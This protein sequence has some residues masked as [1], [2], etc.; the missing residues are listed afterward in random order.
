MKPIALFILILALSM[1][2]SNVTQGVWQLVVV[3]ISGAVVI[4]KEKP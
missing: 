2:A 4:S 1:E 3:F